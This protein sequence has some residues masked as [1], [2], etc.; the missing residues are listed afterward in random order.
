MND[1]SRVRVSGPLAVY[2]SGFV[3]ELVGRGYVRC[4]AVAQVQLMAHL[5][6]WMAEQG[7]GVDDLSGE[8]V[9]EF[10]LARHRARYRH[11]VSP[12][13]VARLLGYLASLGVTPTAPPLAGTPVEKLVEHYGSYLVG[14]RSLA[15]GTVR[16]YLRFARLFL[17]A[18]SIG[19]GVELSELTAAEVSRFVLDECGR[20]SFGSAK[21]L[22]A[23]LRSLLRFLYVEG[24]TA[25]PL[26]A[27][28]PPVAPWRG[29][30]LPRVLD[31]RSMRRLL[32][33]CDRRTTTGRRDH[34]ILVVVSRLGL[35]AGE[36][37]A[38]R[39][40]DIDWRAGEIV[41]R[42]KGDRYERMPLPVDVGETL[43]GYVRRG[44][45]RVESRRLFLRVKAPINGLSGAGVSGVVHAACRRAGLP[46]VGAHRLRHAVAAEMLWRGAGL[47]E[48][49]QVLRQRSSFTTAVYARVDR[50]A[51]RALAR[52]WPGSAP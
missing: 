18:L 51:L 4:S 16:Y 45:P 29:G 21:N 41:V 22:V 37:A 2:A 48:I 38:L 46:V 20:R 32:S 8:R 13:S 31:Q 28:V 50:V 43:A 10:V 52:R 12:R 34:A 39:L 1:P 47:A 5:S 7:L 40:D 24:L 49:G 42:G 11:L 35:R 6:R 3:E 14:E 17:S 30:R 25:N 36:V 9:D 15:A 26:A 19:D 23:A 27:A 33:S 44:R